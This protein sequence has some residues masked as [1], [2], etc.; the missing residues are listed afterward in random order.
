MIEW[1]EYKLNDLNT[2]ISNDLSG[3]Y[4]LSLIPQ[5][6]IKLITEFFLFY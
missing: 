4:S 5:V 6:K 3:N 1:K 2:I